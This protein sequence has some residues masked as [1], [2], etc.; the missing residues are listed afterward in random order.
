MGGGLMQLI[1]YGTS[2]GYLIGNP[3]ICFYKAVYSPHINFAIK[4]INIC[5][6]DFCFDLE[7]YKRKQRRK[8]KQEK[9]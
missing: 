2:N 3:H 4:E 7:K 6:F 1:A 5:D 9:E 8:K